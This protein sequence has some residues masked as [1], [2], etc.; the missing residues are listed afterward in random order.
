M[1]NLNSESAEFKLPKENLVE[2]SSNGVGGGRG[3]GGN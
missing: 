3:V 2:K 1:V